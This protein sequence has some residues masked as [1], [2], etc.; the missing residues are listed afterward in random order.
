MKLKSIRKHLSLIL[1]FSFIIV[2]NIGEIQSQKLKNASDY[3]T[4]IG[5]QYA[6]LSKAY[7]KYV[8][9]AAHSENLEKIEKQ[10]QEL[11]KTSW[12][13]TTTVRTMQTF[14]G[15]RSLRDSAA[16][17]LNLN[18]RIIKED[19]DKILNMEQIASRS[20]N[21]MEAY[22]LAREATANKLDN[23]NK[24]MIEQQKSFAKKYKVDLY[25]R[26]DDTYEKMIETNKVI[27]YYNHIYLIFFKCHKQDFFLQG[28]ILRKDLA[29]IEKYKDELQASSKE[30]LKDLL[31]IMAYNDDASLISSTY[32]VLNFYKDL[33]EN[34]ITQIVAF[35]KEK[36]K[37]MLIQSDFESK[38]ED[39]KSDEDYINYNNAV[40]SYNL[41]ASK[42][43]SLNSSLH[44]KRGNHLEEWNF[45]FENFVDQHIPKF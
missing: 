3:L 43:N 39:E 9:T 5:D 31:Q 24:R 17:Y 28:A 11:L 34:E 32:K 29:E 19:Y 45:V 14:N 25:E 8:S 13:A 37:F 15:D 16:I 30:G 26:D 41:K 40:K 27:K 7:Y 44:S 2:V 18:H 42:Y 23:A 35:E 21:E 20:F 1:T 38:T 12:K 4:Y 10:R 6:S 22:L 36:E 33:S